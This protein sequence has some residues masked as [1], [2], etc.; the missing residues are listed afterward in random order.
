MKCKSPEC[1]RGNGTFWCYVC[2]QQVGEDE[3]YSHFPSGP[4]EDECYGRLWTPPPSPPPPQPRS[5]DDHLVFGRPPPPQR[6]RRHRQRHLQC[7]SGWGGGPC[8]HQGG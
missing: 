6:P 1:R 8:P 5:L 7:H 3:H 2:A 4:F